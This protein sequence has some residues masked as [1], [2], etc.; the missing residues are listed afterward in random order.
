MWWHI[1]CDV[2]K[3]GK[4]KFWVLGVVKWSASVMTHI[5]WCDEV[6]K[7]EVLGIGSSE[8]ECKCDESDET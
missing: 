8:V 2:M 6:S 4:M 1:L 7:Y 3:L 5:V